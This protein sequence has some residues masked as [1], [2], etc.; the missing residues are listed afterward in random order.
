ML[1]R[2]VIV[3]LWASCSFAGAELHIEKR[4][5]HLPVAPSGDRQSVQLSAGGAVV[6]YFD[7]ALP[8]SASE[9]LY[10]SSTDVGAFRGKTLTVSVAPASAERQLLA[11]TRQSDAIREPPL[12]YH[13]RR[14][15]QFH[16]SPM[17]GWTNDPNGL[18]YF[19]GEYHLF[20]QHNPYSI[21]WGNMTWG[22]AVST[23]LVH[24]KELGDALYPDRLGTIFSGSAVVDHR[25][26]SGL[27]REGSPPMLAFFTSAGVHSY[28]TGLPFTQ[29]MAYS[30]DRGRSWTKYEHNPVIDHIEKRN[31]DPKVFWHA[32]S[33]QWVM[34]LYLKRGK[35]VLLGSKNLKQWRKLS[36]VDF[37]DG[38]ECPELFELSVDGDAGRKRW[39]MWEAAGRHRI[40]TFDG[41]R[42]RPETGV[43]PAEWG[44]NTYAAQTYNDAPGGRRILIAWMRS[45]PGPNAP[46]GFYAGMPFN[47]QMSF[48][49]ELSLRS[50]PD[51]V[52]LYAAPAAE[53]R[54]LYIVQQRFTDL[55]LPP[56]DDPLRHAE[57]ELFDIEAEIESRDARS[58]TLGIRGT[59]IVYSAAART[60]SCLGKS[61]TLPPGK[62]RLQLRVLVDRTSIEIF[63]AG[64]RYVMSFCFLPV[65]ANRPLSLTAQ[66]GTAAV[67]SLTVRHLRSI[68]S[69]R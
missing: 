24:W 21:Q 1:L 50:T 48:P 12:V 13:E 55:M 62:G 2:I 29:S 23:D 17:V 58:V 59:P 18:V 69:D 38:Y 36:E 52:R 33:G 63:V 34:A 20:F 5:L 19:A 42:F 22:H 51:G 43:L 26:T 64:G 57:G 27:G 25:N 46:A 45:R 6:R 37:P 7:I 67:A 15:P 32:P 14:R 28:K 47:Q 68:W 8:A 60:L 4:Y 49:R 56:G 16:F 65:D 35:F 11:L 40:G 30:L 44:S 3:W 41:Q 9:A 53:I 10:W 61:V 31:R 39:V 66:G 54:K